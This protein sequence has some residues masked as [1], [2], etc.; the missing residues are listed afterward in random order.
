MRGFSFVR[1]ARQFLLMS[2]NDPIARRVKE[3]LSRM[4][5]AEKI[6]QMSVRMAAG[7]EPATAA[8]LNNQAQK[9]A[10]ARSRHRIPLLL[11]RES[12]HGINTAGV[13]S[14]PASIAMASTW[15]E[16]LNYRI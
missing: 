13:T 3:L 5:L 6:E 8:R 15:D 11:T 4:T 16:D 1:H 7:D 12:S 14:F 10:L 9:E 2:E